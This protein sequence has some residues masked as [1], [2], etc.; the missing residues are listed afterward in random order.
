MFLPLNLDLIWL[1]MTRLPVRCNYVFP[2]NPSYTVWRPGN[3]FEINEGHLF[4][5]N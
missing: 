5:R 4:D 1:E 3:P 2:Y